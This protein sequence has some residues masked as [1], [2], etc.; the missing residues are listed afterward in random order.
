MGAPRRGHGF[1]LIEV[2]I[3]VVIMAVLAAV[4]IPRFSSSTEDAKQSALEYNMKVMREQIQI[5]AAHHLGDLPTIQNNDLPQLTGA[6]DLD[7]N[8]GDPGPD[9]PFGPY[10]KEALPVNPFD[11]S[12]EVTG[13]TLKGQK[14]TGAVGSREGWQ[15]DESNG[16]VWP[17]HP[18]YYRTQ[19]SE[20]E[21]VPGPPVPP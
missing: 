21:S 17:N 2:L 3:V 13:V 19:I 8:I 12:N 18:G 7:G 15:Y 20:A 5:Y 11:Q 9:H 1:T 16:A 4:V 14:P 10:I 6:T